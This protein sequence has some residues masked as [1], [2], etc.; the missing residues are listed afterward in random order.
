MRDE[1]RKEPLP[2]RQTHFAFNLI[3]NA[4]FSQIR[5]TPGIRNWILKKIR[6]E[7]DEMLTKTT[8]GHLLTAVRVSVKLNYTSILLRLKLQDFEDEEG[9]KRGIHLA[10]RR[11]EI[12]FF[13]LSFFVSTSS[14]TTFHCN[15]KI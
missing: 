15:V 13:A 11:I 8:A 12:L 6:F 3:L 7:I 1:I 9:E 10:H 5:F 14:H 2:S 4:V